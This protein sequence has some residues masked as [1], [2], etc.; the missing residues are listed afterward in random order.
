MVDI[1]LTLKSHY[2]DKSQELMAVQKQVNSRYKKLHLNS[3]VKEVGVDTIFA[4][5]TQKRDFH[6]P[7]FAIKQPK[8]SNRVAGLTTLSSP[9]PQIQ[10]GLAKSQFRIR[11]F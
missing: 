5:S 4:I 8:A 7:N 3:K 9:G 10:Y 1:F 6:V 11:V 2:T